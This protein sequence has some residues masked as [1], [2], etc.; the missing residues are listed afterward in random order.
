VSAPLES[1]DT[2]RIYIDS[3]PVDAAR[4]ATPL[5]ALERHDAEAAALVREGA[6]VIVDH[7][8]LPAPLDESVTNGSIFRVVSS[9][10]A[11]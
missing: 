10:Q 4:G 3:R 5:A 6:R 11:S 2:V 7:R 1:A 8:G 9:K